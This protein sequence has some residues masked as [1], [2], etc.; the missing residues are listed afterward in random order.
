MRIALKRALL[1]SG[2]LA[3]AAF[4][5]TGSTPKGETRAMTLQGLPVELIFR[6]FSLNQ[7]DT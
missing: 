3:L 7:S 4:A 1:L 2:W 5:A 6:I